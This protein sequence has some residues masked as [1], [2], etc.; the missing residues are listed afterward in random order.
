MSD[1]TGEFYDII[2]GNYIIF[3]NRQQL[4]NISTRLRWEELVDA[5]E[6]FRDIIRNQQQKQH[7]PVITLSQLYMGYTNILTQG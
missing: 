5:N 6:H 1:H 2:A 4:Y 7:D 3:P